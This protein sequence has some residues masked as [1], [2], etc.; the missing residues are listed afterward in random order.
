MRRSFL[1]TS[2][3]LTA[4]VAGRV[5]SVTAEEP[6]EAEKDKPPFGLFN[7]KSSTRGGAQFWADERFLR[8]WHIQRNSLTGH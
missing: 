8:D 6:R 4:L 7:F 3:L 1:L 5:V 2:V